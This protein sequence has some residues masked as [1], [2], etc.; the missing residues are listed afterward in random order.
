MKD[1][2]LKMEKKKV[3]E[4]KHRTYFTA[5]HWIIYYFVSIVLIKE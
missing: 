5:I 2:H 4:E 1:T 3:G